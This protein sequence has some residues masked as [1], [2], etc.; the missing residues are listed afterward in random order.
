MA[1]LLNYT[2]WTLHFCHLICLDVILSSSQFYV[3]QFPC[4]SGGAPN[5]GVIQISLLTCHN[6]EGILWFCQEFFDMAFLTHCMCLLSDFSR[7]VCSGSLS[8][9]TFFIFGKLVKS[10]WIKMSGSPS[11]P[12]LMTSQRQKSSPSRRRSLRFLHLLWL[13]LGEKYFCLQV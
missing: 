7:K 12:D 1:Y 3:L 2:P 8:S 5:F 11:P 4:C 10:H 9:F 13:W 6:S